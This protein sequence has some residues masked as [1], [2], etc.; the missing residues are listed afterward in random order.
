MAERPW[1]K[2]YHSDALSG[3]IVL[4]L[5]ERGAYQTLL[6]LIYDRGG[7]MPDNDG[8]LARYMG[9][10]IRKWKS[11]RQSLITH[12][13]IRVDT[14]GFLTNDRAIAEIEG[15]RKISKIRS[16]N[17]AKT[18]RKRDE[19]ETKIDRKTSETSKKDN[20]NNERDDNL[21]LYARAFPETRYQNIEPS[22][23]A[24]SRS[25]DEQGCHDEVIPANP[26]G[27]GCGGEAIP[28]K[29]KIA[30]TE[31]DTAIEQ[32]S[33]SAS[34]R[35]WPVPRALTDQR[36]KKLAARLRTH[37]LDG[38]RQ[39]LTKAW[40][41]PLLS[42]DPPPSWFSLDWLIRNDEN[43]LKVLEGN[44]DRTGN[45]FGGGPVAPTYTPTRNLS[46]DEREAARQ[47]LIERGELQA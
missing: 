16:E 18:A 5:E 40:Q 7:P 1:H 20:E 8:L 19:N 4:S 46:T 9:V 21:P 23:L 31:I 10:S 2:R 33:V 15:Q 29:P 41:S 44:Y 43:L 3:F 30:K 24:N 12:G 42:A 36:R 25:P 6:D 26:S 39:V 32:W 45:G 35:G 28:A 37:G 22:V 47:R 27:Q 17:G 34:K 11:L 14:E 38:W 13:K